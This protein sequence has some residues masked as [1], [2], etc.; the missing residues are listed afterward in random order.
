MCIPLLLPRGRGWWR[1][2]V[3]MIYLTAPVSADMYALIDDVRKGKYNI[4][5]TPKL[6]LLLA[7]KGHNKLST[8]SES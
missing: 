6:R 7:K 5:R 2:V 1:V 4:W 8:L 3:T